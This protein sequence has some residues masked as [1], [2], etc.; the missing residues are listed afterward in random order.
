MRDLDAHSWVEAYFPS[1]GWVTFDPTPAAS[2]ASSQ[3]DD[4]ANVPVPSL[5]QVTPNGDRAADPG[6]PGA[7]AAGQGGSGPTV[8]L[9]AALLLAGGLVAAGWTVVRRGRLPGPPPAPELFDLQR[10]LHRSGRTPP[11][12]TT[13]RRL[14]ETLGG[15]PA[16]RD[17][18]RALRAQRYAGTGAGPTAAQRR[19]LREELA[20][21]LGLRGRVRALWALPPRLRGRRRSAP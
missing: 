11:A 4:P 9:A 13:L 12:R 15:T 3:S 1:I 2:P 14:E 8:L 20:A 16:A 5:G 17:Y 6:N 10:A 19:A 18:L 7:R 21:G